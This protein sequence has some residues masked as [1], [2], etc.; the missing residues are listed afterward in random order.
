MIEITAVV[1]GMV[2]GGVFV[3]LV[4]RS[5][6]SSAEERGR[7]AGESELAAM[8]ERISSHESRI[9]ELKDEVASKESEIG[10]GVAENTALKEELATLETRL[11]EE[12]RT[13]AEKLQI[14]EESKQKLAAEFKNLANEIFEAKNSKFKEESKAALDTII[15]PLGEKIS[16]FRKKVE[17]THEKNIKEQASLREAIS[18]LKDMNAKLSEDA[19]NLTTALKGDTKI[20]GNWGELVLE[21][22][23]EASGLQ[24][25]VQYV[26]QESI[27]EENG[28][29]FQPDV[30]INLPEG[31]HVVIDSKVSMVA[32]ERYCSEDDK[33]LRN[34]YQKE[35]VVSLRRHIRE[36][37]EKH[38]QDLNKL[39]TLDFVFMFIP[40]E[41]ATALALQ[42][43]T[44]V[45]FEAS[46]S[47]IVIV[48][49][50][51]LLAALKTISYLWRQE[52][53]NR[54]AAEIARLSGE[55]YNKFVNFVSDLDNIGK[56]IKQ[57]DAAYGAAMN[58]LKSGR[59]NI[60]VT[61][62]KIKLKGARTNKELPADLVEEAAESEAVLSTAN[63]LSA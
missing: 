50:S 51:T 24:K 31:K 62:E 46:K 56:R 21:R 54:N 60:L 44:D 10:K 4:L 3:W 37:S 13:T 28:K 30:I 23:L 58:K 42:S 57:T 26:T 22:I 45:F 8:T 9:S 39:K 38:Y 36:L 19:H 25:G 35:H 5:Q 32:Y 61:I 7:M 1:V 40:I 52:S 18:S 11:T 20:Q 16:D 12:R 2:A 27:T 34:K 63:N 59:G 43:E 53:Q 41:S 48:T 6:I 17:D 29:R 47:K 55:L 49:P 33:E 15:K 14:L